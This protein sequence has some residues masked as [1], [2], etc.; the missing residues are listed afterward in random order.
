MG[1]WMCAVELEEEFPCRDIDAASA[2]FD[3]LRLP[4]SPNIWMELGNGTFRCFKVFRAP[5]EV[6]DCRLVAD[7]DELLGAFHGTDCNMVQQIQDDMDR[8]KPSLL[9]YCSRR[10]AGGSFAV[11]DL[12]EMFRN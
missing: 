7:G 8:G 12:A 6:N 5:E 4:E 1:M 2:V 3:Q 10:L 11:I 9:S